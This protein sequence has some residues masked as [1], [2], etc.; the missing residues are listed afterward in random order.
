VLSARGDTAVVSLPRLWYHHTT[1]FGEQPD[2][3]EAEDRAMLAYVSG[4]ED[5]F[6]AHLLESGEEIEPVALPGAEDT[7]TATPE[8]T[9]ISS[10]PT[11]DS[12]G[13]EDLALN[14]AMRLYAVYRELIRAQVPARLDRV[15]AAVPPECE[16]RRCA[17]LQR[18]IVFTALQG[19]AQARAL[20]ELDLRDDE[21]VSEIR[22]L[23]RQL[24]QEVGRGGQG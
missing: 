15:V 12:A 17:E 10:S 4:L 19:N 23:F 1:W 20:N 2:W 11:M 24:R 7:N 5:A 6:P 3:P 13:N 16:N 18:A 14:A 21:S 22:E 8:A 9:G